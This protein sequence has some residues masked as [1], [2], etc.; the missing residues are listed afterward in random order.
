MPT[1]RR[2]PPAAD[3]RAPDYVLAD[4]FDGLEDIHQQS[5]AQALAKLERE[6]PII[7]RHWGFPE[8]LVTFRRYM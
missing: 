3:R 4:G 7:A 2:N 1:K 6:F 8:Q 5:S